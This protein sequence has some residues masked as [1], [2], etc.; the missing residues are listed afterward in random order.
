MEEGHGSNV[1]QSH[2]MLFILIHNILC[3]VHHSKSSPVVSLCTAL[4][5]NSTHKQCTEEF[6]VVK[7]P[8]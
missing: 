7:F 5:D 6:K 2:Y 8:D 1:S 3:G 4:W